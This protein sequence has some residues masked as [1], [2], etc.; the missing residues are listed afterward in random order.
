M[1]CALYQSFGDP[2]KVLAVG[3]APLPQPRA[4]EVRIRTLLAPIHNHDL[5]TVRGQY[6]YRPALPAIGGSEAVGIV[7]ALGEGVEGLAVGQRVAT[8]AGRGT[9]AEYFIA[10]A[11]MT[12]PL[13]DG[14]PDETAAQLLAM[15]L[16]ALMLLETLALPAGAWIVQNAANGAVGKAL[17]M[18]AGARGLRVVNIV[19][20]EAGVAALTA[21]GLAHVVCSAHA[22]W[23]QQVRAITGPQLAQAAIDSVGGRASG[24]LLALLGEGGVLVSFGA[25]T[26]E[27]MQLSPADLIFKQAIVKGFWGSKASQALSA[28]ERRRLVGELLQRALAGE[29]RLPV[30]AVHDLADIG[31]AAAASLR[32]GRPGKVLLRP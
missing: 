31:Q 15:P 19:R 32:P 3:D 23:M 9:W 7:D 2:T 13:P 10:P 4:G 11:R 22:D 8:P 12:V 18:L 24:A 6:G 25:L 20:G 21:L 27:P 29:L 26:G 5:L 14:I 16:S 17:A 28:E 1:R 30:D